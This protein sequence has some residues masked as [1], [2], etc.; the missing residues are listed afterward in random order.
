MSRASLTASTAFVLALFAV[1]SVK[2]QQAPPTLPPGMQTRTVQMSET[3]DA[4][5]VFALLTSTNANWQLAGVN[6]NG[7]NFSILTTDDVYRTEPS[8]SP[9]GTRIVFSKWAESGKPILF[10]YDVQNKTESSLNVS[11][12]VPVFS[13]DG[14]KIAFL[15]QSSELSLCDADGKNVKR[16]GQGFASGSRPAWS[17]DSVQLLVAGNSRDTQKG[18]AVYSIEGK[19]VRLLYPNEA[20]NPSWSSDGST[21]TFQA[22]ADGQPAGTYDVYTASAVDGK[23]LRRLTKEGGSYPTFAADGLKIAFINKG[24]IYTIYKDGSGLTVVT[25]VRVPV[26]FLT[27]IP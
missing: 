14:K 17:P 15:S 25:D 4:R 22:A 24:T 3:F 8:F 26:Q 27:W 16:L 7:A 12:Y 19:G 2:A 9:D 5:L 21:V 13:P 1:T 20:L 11:G 10:M 23:G 18:V 6:L